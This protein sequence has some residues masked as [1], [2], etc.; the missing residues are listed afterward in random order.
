MDRSWLALA[1]YGFWFLVA[2]G[3]RTLIHLR[4]TGST[5]FRG[6]S[7]KPGSLEWLAGVLLVVSMALG[8]LG[9]FLHGELPR[10]EALERTATLVT[11]IALFGI[12]S[13]ATTGAQAAMGSSWRVGVD[14]AEGTELVTTGAFSVTRNPIFTTMCITAAGLFLVVP[15]AVSLTSLIGVVIAL[16]MQVRLVEEPHL[17]RVHGRRF[18]QYASRVG[19]FVPGVGRLRREHRQ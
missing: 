4:R 18:L 9:A 7:G 8:L 17:L 16:Q 19:R 13:A 6:I 3:L 11:G 14:E 5:G 10:L 2:F 1:L 15:N 12:G